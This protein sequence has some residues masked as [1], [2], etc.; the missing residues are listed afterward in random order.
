MRNRHQKIKN[1][2]KKS[3]VRNPPA[4]Q[5]RRNVHAVRAQ[6]AETRVIDAQRADSVVIR[7]FVIVFQHRRVLQPRAI[8]DQ[9]ANIRHSLLIRGGLVAALQER[10]LYAAEISF[11]VD[12]RSCPHGPCPLPWNRRPFPHPAISNSFL[13]SLSLS[14]NRRPAAGRAVDGE[15]PP[16]AAAAMAIARSSPF[17]L[18]YKIH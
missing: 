13:S 17:A 14:W 18:M 9:A 7:S 15:T 4:L 3:N 5:P 8:V 12:A 16:I 11:P 10:V 1:K 2:N 6:A